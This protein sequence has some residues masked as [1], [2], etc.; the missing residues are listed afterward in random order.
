VVHGA[1]LTA[2]RDYAI[3]G[4]RRRWDA[5]RNSSI[6]AVYWSEEIHNDVAGDGLLR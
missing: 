3:S 4:I 6:V 5:K 1:T 2:P